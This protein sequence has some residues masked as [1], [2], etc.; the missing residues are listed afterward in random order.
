M[1]QNMKVKVI[2]I[3]FTGYSVTDLKRAR[4]FL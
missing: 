1:E 3:A 2:E 4:G